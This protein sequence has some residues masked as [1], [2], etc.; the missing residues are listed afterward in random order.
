M[1]DKNIAGRSKL[2]GPNGLLS[3]GRSELHVPHQSLM[4]DAMP[5][6]FEPAAGAVV[7]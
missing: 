5:S 4:G 3:M 2:V 6:F 7:N 1:F